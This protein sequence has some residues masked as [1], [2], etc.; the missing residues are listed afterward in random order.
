MNTYT[1]RV[2]REGKWWMARVPDIDALT[3]ARRLGEVEDM[4]RSL[5]AITLG[6][7]A[8]SF[9][10]RAELDAIE[11]IRVTERLDRIHDQLGRAAHLEEEA[12]A[13]TRALA[14]ELSGKGVPVRDIGTVLG[15]SFQRA[16]QLV[17]KAD[18]PSDSAPT[19]TV[20]A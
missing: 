9:K 8:D 18:N 16:Q 19:L 15:V 17:R 6:I 11:D 4:A 3:Q 2:T 10:I 1:V 14:A 7:P 13:H 12:R 5:I 20:T